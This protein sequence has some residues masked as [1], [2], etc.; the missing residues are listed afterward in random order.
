MRKIPLWAD[1]PAG[2]DPTHHYWYQSLDSRFHRLCDRAGWMEIPE[3]DNIPERPMR[4]RSCSS[5]GFED[6]QGRE[7]FEL[8]AGPLPI[9]RISIHSGF[10]PSSCPDYTWYQDTC[11]PR[12]VNLLD[13]V[14]DLQIARFC[15]MSRQQQFSTVMRRRTSG[16]GGGNIHQQ[17]VSILKELHWDSGD[18]EFLK[19]QLSKRLERVSIEHNRRW[20][21]KS[22]IEA[23]IEHWETLDAV[24]QAPPVAGQLV[25]EGMTIKVR[26]EIGVRPFQADNHLLKLWLYSKPP[27]RPII[28]DII[29]WL[30]KRLREQNGG[31]NSW[32]TGLWVVE[33]KSIVWSSGANGLVEDMV[34]GGVERYFKLLNKP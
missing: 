9:S 33:K 11:Q 22:L 27:R 28:A 13:T 29:N 3:V 21:L 23:Y 18:I 30:V 1:R 20:R 32:P 7:S 12:E 34:R 26:P 4:C 10:I 5:I 15:V 2:P 6:W 14:S 17:I 25:I 8:L 31:G 19:Q 16:G 24:Y